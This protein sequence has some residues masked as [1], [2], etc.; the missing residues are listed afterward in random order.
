MENKSFSILCFSL[1]LFMIVLSISLSSCDKNKDVIQTLNGGSNTS[2]SS[3]IDTSAPIPGGSGIL[4]VTPNTST[5][6]I[7]SWVKATDGTSGSINLTYK[8]YYSM[9]NNINTIATAESNG[10]IVG[11]G[12]NIA[13]FAVT[14]LTPGAS[15]YFAVVVSDTAGNKAIYTSGITNTLLPYN[16]VS[17]VAN[18][19]VSVIDRTT[20]TV[21][22]TIAVGASPFGLAVNASTNK[23]YVANFASSSVSVI[24][25]TTGVVI[26]TITVGTN[27]VGIDVNAN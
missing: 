25:G 7:I 11:S 21:I 12:I 15:Y 23:I 10:T 27:P 18:S 26:N 24:D 22:K 13:T 14:G 5:S 1:T 6:A 2:P 19:N 9:A 3:G 20:D 4:T 8:V 17:N 16:Y